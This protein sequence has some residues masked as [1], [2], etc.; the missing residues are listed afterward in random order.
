LWIAG[1]D[2]QGGETGINP[3]YRTD[4]P[5]LSRCQPQKKL[6]SVYLEKVGESAILPYNWKPK[7][8]I[9]I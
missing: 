3:T 2:W 1:G 9:L 4:K 5:K 8:L 7:E 6:A